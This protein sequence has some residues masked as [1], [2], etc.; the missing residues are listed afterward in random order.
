[1]E[2]PLQFVGCHKDTL[3][4]KLDTPLDTLYENW[5]SRDTLDS[6]YIP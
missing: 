6:K 2:H 4:K 5:M 3:V 1:M